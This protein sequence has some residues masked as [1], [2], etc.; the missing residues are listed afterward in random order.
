MKVG[1]IMVETIDGGPEA[2]NPNMISN[3]AMF[4]EPRGT[5]VGLFMNGG[6]LIRTKFTTID[7][8]IDYIKRAPI[9]TLGE[10]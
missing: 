4:D 9:V 3:L 6:H 8:A 5:Y 10:A 2:V 1:F 7:H